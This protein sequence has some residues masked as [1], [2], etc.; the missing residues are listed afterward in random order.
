MYVRCPQKRGGL[1]AWGVGHVS[2]HHL[3]DWAAGLAGALWEKVSLAPSLERLFE[4]ERE[5][6]GE[7]EEVHIGFFSL[8]GQD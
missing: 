5:S 2:I 1:A 6:L 8:R 4:G 7:E 3:L